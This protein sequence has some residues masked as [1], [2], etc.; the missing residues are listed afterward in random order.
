MQRRYL[1]WVAV[2]LIITVL[3]GFLTVLPT[4]QAIAYTSS[5]PILLDT[6]TPTPDAS[7]ILQMAQQEEVNIQTILTFIGI[8]LVVFPAL[9]AVASVVLGVVGF[10]GFN[11]F[12]KKGEAA[13][14]KVEE[15]KGKV[16]GYSTAIEHT[17]KAI[18]Y[19]GLG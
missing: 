17:Q 13:L 5:A 11:D 1:W 8:I 10:R 2:V 16:D 19:M 3:S 12:Q 7:T 18:A 14:A 6:P 9:L 4:T 15:I